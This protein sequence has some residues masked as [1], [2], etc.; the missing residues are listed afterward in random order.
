VRE[1][2]LS[3]RPDTYICLSSGNKAGIAEPLKQWF[4]CTPKPKLAAQRNSTASRE[5]FATTMACVV[6]QCFDWLLS[7]ALNRAVS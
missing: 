1:S 4:S 3:N 7:E 6:A 2:V 5:S